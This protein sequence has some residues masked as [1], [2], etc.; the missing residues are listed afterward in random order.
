M[1]LKDAISAV[2]AAVNLVCDAVQKIIEHARGQDA[3]L[4]DLTARLAALE[5]R[6]GSHATPGS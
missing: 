3:R 1:D 4:D 5:E 6:E 2:V